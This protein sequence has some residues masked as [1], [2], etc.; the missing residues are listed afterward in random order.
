MSKAVSPENNNSDKRFNNAYPAYIKSRDDMPEPVSQGGDP[1]KWALEAL[2]RVLQDRPERL[3]WGQ[4]D[5]LADAERR[6]K[7]TELAAHS[8][9]QLIPSAADHARLDAL[10]DAIGTRTTQ[11]QID[12]SHA[13]TTQNHEV[14]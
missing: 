1:S 4:V 9:G 5:A 7:I 10:L 11:D 13:N 3:D 14:I 12:I 8:A 2:N 6:A